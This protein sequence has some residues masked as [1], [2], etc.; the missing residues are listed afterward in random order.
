MS[1]PNGIDAD[2]LPT[3]IQIAGPPDS[4]DRLL[5]VGYQI[6]RALGLVDRLGIEP[7]LSSLP[8]PLVGEG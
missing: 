7:R 6:E 4:E 1:I 5:R 8:S 3:G 2:G